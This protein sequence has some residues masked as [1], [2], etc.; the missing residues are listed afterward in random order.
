MTQATLTREAVDDSEE[1]V[2]EG[3]LLGRPVEDRSFE[4]VE[5]GAGLAAGAAVGAAI[6]GPVGAAAG[7]LVGATMGIV[8]GEAL[9]RAEGRAAT[10]TDAGPRTTTPAADTRR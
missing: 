9:E 7:A 2:D 10:T 4:M 5:T 1:P 8:G 3:L 6:A